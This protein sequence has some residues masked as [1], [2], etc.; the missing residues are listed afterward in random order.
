[1]VGLRS[2]VPC[3]VPLLCPSANALQMPMRQTAAPL[4]AAAG[5]LE[6]AGYLPFNMQAALIQPIGS[7]G[8]LV[9]GSDTQRGFSRLDQVCMMGEAGVLTV[10][11]QCI[12]AYLKEL[13]WHG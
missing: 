7:E 1:M 9:V 12:C 4:P 5:R 8:V 11:R 13:G 10:S 3:A 2:H 6:F